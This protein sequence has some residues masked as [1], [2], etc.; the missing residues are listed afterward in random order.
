MIPKIEG[1]GGGGVLSRKPSQSRISG[2]KHFPSSVHKAK[3]GPQAAFPKIPTK[4]AI[5]LRP[6]QGPVLEVIL[7][8]PRGQRWTQ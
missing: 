7:Q 8:N 6:R 4:P 5:S 3:G 1:E 2:Q